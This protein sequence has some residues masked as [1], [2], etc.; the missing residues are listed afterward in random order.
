MKKISRRN[1]F[2]KALPLLGGLLVAAT[3]I[4]G[5]VATDCKG[6]CAGTCKFMCNY[7]CTAHVVLTA[8]TLVRDLA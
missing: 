8:S 5:Q 6:G 1:F 3:P 7:N 4:L 2:S